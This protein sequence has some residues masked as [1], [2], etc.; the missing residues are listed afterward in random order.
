[1]EQNHDKVFRVFIKGKIGR[2]W[3][4]LTKIDSPQG[5]VYNARMHRTR[6]GAGAAFKMRSADGRHTM[7]QGD[8]LEWE[9]PHRF[10]HTFQSTMH[11]DPPCIVRYLL[12]ERD[13]GVDVT[14]TLEKLPQGT[15][16]AKDMLQGATFIL[17]N[18]Q[19]LI[20]TGTLPF[21]TRL[22]YAMF[23]RMGFMLPKK[24]R[25]EHWPLNES[26]SEDGSNKEA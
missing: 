5:A 19:A 10:A 7:V 14:M 16:T 4:E 13:D 22:M 25:S 8:I 17:G 24:M 23:A 21:K 6:D 3:E 26:R 15:K 9:P 20:E 11:M 18:L 2:V 12:T 1:M